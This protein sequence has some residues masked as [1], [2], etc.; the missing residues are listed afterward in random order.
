[1]IRRPRLPMV[2]VLDVI[3]DIDFASSQ[4]QL[5][6]LREAA[7]QH[8]IGV[9]VLR[10]NSTGGSIAAA[11][12]LCEAVEALRE[13]GVYVLACCGDVAKSAALYVAASA[14]VVLAQAGTVTGNVGAIMRHTSLSSLGAQFG[15]ED[16]VVASGAFKDPTRLASS[17]SLHELEVMQSLV[18]GIHTQ[19]CDWLVR[20]R[21][22]TH[23]NLG[24]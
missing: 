11:Q 9:L 24:I 6:Q 7:T 17:P 19:F 18:I 2:A 21:G 23:D 22:T 3:G 20:R 5:H 16:V 8:R 14:D 12:Q 4:K 15:I 1:M 13:S 10:I